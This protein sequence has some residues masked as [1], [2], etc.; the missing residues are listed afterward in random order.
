MARKQHISRLAAPATWPIKRKGLKWIAKPMPG[1]H[2]L[3]YSM[4]QVIY[5]RDILNLAESSK[6]IKYIINQG[7]VLVNGKKRKELNFPIGLFDVIVILKMGKFYRVVLNTKNQLIL[8][9][10]PEEEAN[11]IPL[12]VLRK[13]ITKGK[14]IQL[15]FNNGWSIFTDNNNIKPGDTIIF[16][17]NKKEIVSHIKLKADNSVY[18]IGGNYTGNIAVLKNI[19]EIGEFRKTRLAVIEI[20]KETRE[21]AFDYLFTIGETKPEIKLQ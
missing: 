4:A 19:K 5:L 21:T 17:F 8:I 6:N 7:L 13:R 15:G 10:I 18:L 9:E 11:L 12:K 14:R 1:P 2:N 16:D 3:Q 20:G